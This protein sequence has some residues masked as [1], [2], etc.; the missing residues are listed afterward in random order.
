ME[1]FALDLLSFAATKASPD[2]DNSGSKTAAELQ[3]TCTFTADKSDLKN[4][5]QNEDQE[6]PQVRLFQIRDWWFLSVNI[7]LK[8]LF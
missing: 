5:R 4:D 3:P 8:K 7:C 1:A 6:V 2:N